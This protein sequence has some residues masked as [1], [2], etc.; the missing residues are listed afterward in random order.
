MIKKQ[1][2]STLSN[3]IITFDFLPNDLQLKQKK[4][5]LG[6]YSKNEIEIRIIQG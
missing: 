4:I 2:Y 3:W 1:L 6:K 5:L